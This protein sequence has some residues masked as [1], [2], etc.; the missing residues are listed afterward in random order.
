MTPDK[1]K[2]LQELFFTAHD[3]PHDERDRFIKES[4][5][6]DEA[7]ARELR[8]L[9]L[10]A[11]QNPGFLERPVID[12]ALQARVVDEILRHDDALLSSVGPYRLLSVIGE[13]G[14]ARVYLAEQLAPLRRRVAVKVLRYG[15]D[16]ANVLKRFGAERQA[17][18]YL[19]HP[20]VVS[21]IDAGQLD[22]GTRR[23]YFVME[24][25]PG[26]PITTY[27]ER[28]ELSIGERVKLLVR[29]FDAVQHAH[30]N[31][32]IHRDLK[33]SNI[34]VADIDGAPTPKII[35]FGVAKAI[36]QTQLTDQSL[37]TQQGELLGTLE[38]MSPE[39]LRGESDIRS[40]VYALGVLAYELLAGKPPIAVRR[41]GIGAAIR[42][43]EETT[44]RP[45][46][47]QNAACDH[48]LDIVVSTALAKDPGRRYQ[49]AGAMA[50]DLR[51]VLGHLPIHARKPSALYL[52]RQFCRR[53]K[54]LATVTAVAFV[55]VLGFAVVAWR[56]QHKA[57]CAER[58]TR[59]YAVFMAQTTLPK[60]GVLS[61]TAEVRNDIARRS[62]DEV[63]EQ[64]KRRPD[65]PELLDV[66]A[67]ALRELSSTELG[68]GQ[69]ETALRIRAEAVETRRRAFALAPLDLRILGSLSIDMV[70]LGDLLCGLQREPEGWQ[71]YEAAAA[72]HEQLVRADRSDV[73][74]EYLAWSQERLSTAALI[75]GDIDEAQRRAE[76]CLSVSGEL[77][78][79]DPQNPLAL[80]A[81][82]AAHMVCARVADAHGEVDIVRAHVDQALPLGR[83]LV[84]SSSSRASY[85]VDYVVLLQ[86][87]GDREATREKAEA[88]YLEARDLMDGLERFG[89]LDPS[90]RPLQAACLQRLASLR[91]DQG[92]AD[93]ARQ[94]VDR[95]LAMRPRLP[96]PPPDDVRGTVDTH[97]AIGA[98]LERLG[99][100]D[101]ADEFL[102][103]AFQWQEDATRT[104]PSDPR[105]LW[106]L[107]YMLASK[108]SG[109][110]QNPSRA[111]ELVEIARPHTPRLTPWHI[112]L[113]QSVTRPNSDE[114]H[115]P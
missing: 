61:G 1:H 113:I 60:L 12:A 74:L 79:R 103:A 14:F 49:S 4:C 112:E 48:D 42:A 68:A 54:G 24:Y 105:E 81:V 22:D 80:H 73:H 96:A 27:C 11:D 108:H 13:G 19:S 41:L 2:R 84:E 94:L 36:G 110:Y 69:A 45:L 39:Q 78:E 8:N 111:K 88:R 44:P 102:G 77:L 72:L 62:R 20:S 76:D 21:I 86:F 65:D 114:D 3:L 53:R 75:R 50:D 37:H 99:R 33:P 67:T 87:A 107:A 91:L 47:V 17:L 70:L 43:I 23:P 6:E 93:E 46:R 66:L 90:A 31:G 40:D 57:R 106:A 92:R 83:F 28:L 9:L 85:V 109:R 25:V 30:V 10:H 97:W 18:A 35:D 56:E 95:L 51:R 16:S 29:V 7:L 38:Y 98:L 104:R 55:A 52:L 101:E 26:E 15:M 89:L 59:E 5:G 63:L 32:V 82:R 115:V 100:S 58:A 64:L 34:L 71:Q